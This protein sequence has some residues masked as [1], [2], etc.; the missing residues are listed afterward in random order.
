MTEHPSAPAAWHGVPILRRM[1]P[2]RFIAGDTRVTNDDV[3]MA[4]MS[5]PRSSGRL[6]PYAKPCV[7][8]EALPAQVCSTFHFLTEF[9]VIK[10]S[11]SNKG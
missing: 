4:R 2:T 5:P 10:H 9:V 6:S 11:C 8:A 7:P 1:S 3:E